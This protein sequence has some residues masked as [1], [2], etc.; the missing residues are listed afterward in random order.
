MNGSSSAR[1]RSKNST[2]SRGTTRF[3]SS[4]AVRQRNLQQFVAQ[5]R[6]ISPEDGARFQQVITKS[7][8]IATIAPGLK[9]FSLRTDDV[10]DTATTYL[11]SS[12]YGV[13]GSTQDPPQNYVN[14]V[15]AQMRSAMLAVPSFAASS[16]ATKQHMAESLLL[17]V[18]VNEALITAARN[19]P[20]QMAQ[21]K[22]SIKQGA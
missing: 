6:R 2:P 18:M 16:D 17:Q 21:A 11:I 13:R 8:P 1:L 3:R 12:W 20:S 22:Q 15:R 14:G 4:A 9:R 5:L 7:D 10:A 19:K